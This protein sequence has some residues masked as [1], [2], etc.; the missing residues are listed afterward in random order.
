M[1]SSYRT[2]MPGKSLRGVKNTIAIA[3]GKG[4]VGKSTVTVNLAITLAKSGARVGILDADIYGPS[5][6]MMLG[7]VD[8]V[9]VDGDRYRP[10]EAHGVQAMSI[11]YLTEPNSAL[12]W[13]GPML[14]KSMIQMLDCTAWDNL[15]Y[16]LID[17]PPGTGDIQLSL[18]QKIPLTAAIVVT[19]PQ[20]VA[21]HDAQK[22]LTLF[23]TMG[24]HVLGI[25]ENMSHHHCPNCHHESALFGAG[26]AQALCDTYHCEFLG[27]LPLEGYVVNDGDRGVPS[28]LSSHPFSDAFTKIADKAEAALRLRPLNYADKF[29]PLVVE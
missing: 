28:C 6:P 20:N 5:I 29:P 8:P 7:V 4:G 18:V 12:I 13:R 21:T 23:N 22:A 15:D 1:I 24:I 9:Q 3:S 10:I 14:A 19:T 17:L 27:Q 2:Q 11:G 26:G 25:I 16:L